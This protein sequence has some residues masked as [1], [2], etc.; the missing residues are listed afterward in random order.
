MRTHYLKAASREALIAALTAAGMWREDRF[1]P[2]TRGDALDEIG[3][4]QSDGVAVV[5]Y[6]ANLM[7]HGEFHAELAVIEIPAPA[8]PV[9]VWA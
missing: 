1:F 5:G 2:A 6:H 9:R 8:N 4:I 3:T 7:L